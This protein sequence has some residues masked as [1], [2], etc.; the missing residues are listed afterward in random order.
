MKLQRIET[1]DYILWVS[2]EEIKE[3]DTI[4]YHHPKQSFDMA[5]IH[6]VINPNYSLDESAYRVK[7]DTGWGVIEGC[8]KIIAYQPKNNTSELLPTVQYGNMTFKELN[9]DGSWYKCI[10]CEVETT[11]SGEFLKSQGV[12]LYKNKYELDLPLLPEIVVEDDVELKINKALSYWKTFEGDQQKGIVYGLRLALEFYKSATNTYSEEDLRKA[13]SILR[14]YD[15]YKL[16]NDAI[17][18]SL[19]QPKTPKYFVAEMEGYKINGMIDEA[20][21]YILKTTTINGK[22]YLVGTYLYE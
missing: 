19:K 9:G 3:G 4:F 13:L 21:S 11:R 5:S 8:K 22:T 10:D 7:F 1:P 12:Q 15:G 14:D 6:K 17:I 20:T 18:Q 2:D 16:S